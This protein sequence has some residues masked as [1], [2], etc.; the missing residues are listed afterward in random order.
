MIRVLAT[1]VPLLVAG[2]VASFPVGPSDAG[3]DAA[4]DADIADGDAGCPDGACD[5]APPCMDAA[6]CT[7]CWDGLSCRPGDELAACGAE[8]GQCLGCATNERCSEGACIPDTY[9]AALYLSR[10]TSCALDADEGLWCWG[11]NVGG[12]AGAGEGIATLDRPS[13]VVPGTR[14]RTAAIGWKNSSHGCG[15]RDDG[16][17]YCWG[18]NVQ[19]QL[20]I[21]T[22]DPSYDPVAVTAD[23]GPAYESL[24]AGGSTTCA[25]R[26]GGELWCWG[27]GANFQIPSGAGN[28]LTPIRAGSD[29]DWLSLDLAE[30]YGCGLREGGLLAC[31]GD[32]EEGQLGF[33][34]AGAPADAQVVLDGVEA[35]SVGQ[36][37]TC[38]V[39]S[40]QVLCW[41]RNVEAQC[42]APASPSV[43]VPTPVPLEG[44]FVGV[45][46]GRG[47]T[48][49]LEEGGHL[50]C[51]GANDRGQLGLGEEAVEDALHPP[52]L[53]EGPTWVDVDAGLN[54]T[55]A[56]TAAQGLYCWGNNGGGQVGAG[57][58]DQPSPIAVRLGM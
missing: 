33:G 36:L 52:S 9:A 47:H 35:Y 21:G 34:S 4:G 29:S 54:H 19:G 15:L 49:A 5:A 30:E 6:C 18:Q 51:W 23:S 2:C 37:H 31:W 40:G 20:G 44:T 25:V 46:T 42:G 56:R 38:A 28:S 55:C 43:M 8:G 11:Q 27:N 3:M 17:P 16:E 13:Q 7:G 57:R 22:T 24:S 48:C 26:G 14:W 50:Y 32:N 10:D 58:R 1:A 45:A 39:K 53:V 41:G 12:K